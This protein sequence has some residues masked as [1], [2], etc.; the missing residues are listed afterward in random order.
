[1]HDEKLAAWWNRLSD[2]VR[3]DLMD[4]PSQQLSE[5]LLAAA[6]DAGGYVLGASL[7]EQG[8]HVGPTLTPEAVA[9]VREQAAER[10]AGLAP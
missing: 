8:A 10:E 3:D 1:M 4:D 2:G 7:D 6:S 9:F 5:R